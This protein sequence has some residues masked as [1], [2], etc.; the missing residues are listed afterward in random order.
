MSRPDM[1]NRSSSEGAQN[2]NSD[3]TPSI[4]RS[5]TSTLSPSSS[6]TSASPP[7]NP[8]DHHRRAMSFGLLR[9][10]S[11]SPRPPP[12]SDLSISPP[13][14]LKHAQTSPVQSSKHDQHQRHRSDGAVAPPPSR[15]ATSPTSPGIEKRDSWIQKK[16][17]YSGSSPGGV[18]RHGNEWLFG[19]FSITGTVKEAVRARRKEED[20]EGSGRG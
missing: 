5:P 4:T 11:K 6:Y 7:T 14:P 3:I 15:S 1:K 2:T 8:K 17:R 18:G 16:P 9:S 10:R 12:P 20:K 19:G 13:S